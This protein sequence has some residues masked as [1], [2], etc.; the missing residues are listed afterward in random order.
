MKKEIF[1]DYILKWF[2]ELGF[3]RKSYLEE[4][5]ILDKSNVIKVITWMR[6]VWKSFILKQFIDEK[7]ESWVKKE[8]IFYLH[9]EDYRFW[10]KPDLKQ[11]WELFNYFLE[12]IYKWWDFYIFLDEIQNVDSWE[13]FV[14]TINEKYQNSAHIFITWSNSNLLSSELSTLLTWRFISLQVFPFSFKDYLEFK[15][16]EL[17]SSLD[18]KK[19]DYFEEYIKYWSLPEI[20]KIDDEN[21]KSN[22]LKTLVDSILFKDIITRYKLRKTTFISSLLKFIYTNTCSILSINSILKFLKQDIKSLDYETVDNYISYL[23]NS[24][25][26]N[27]IDSKNSK[28]KE[29]LK[30]NKKYYSYDLG[31]RNI[32]SN[33]F[34]I[35][36]ILE[37]YVYLELQRKWYKVWV[38]NNPNY[39]I[40]FFAEKNDE[41]IYFQVSYTIKNKETYNR[42]IKP[43]LLQKDNYKKVILT[44]DEE[45]REDRWIFIKNIINWSI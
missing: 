28:T 26:I 30:S 43:F 38:I 18:T 42:E 13:K 4:L 35:E 1:F 41:K 20:L 21:I 29:I 33:N 6:R 39:E 2:W 22:Y 11:L 32:Y 15:N 25:L 45:E 7:I 27:K 34:D 44:L 31:I 14:R 19:I 24:F 37:N 23:E 36:K 8:N 9:L 40:D 3:L 16:L 10:N 12:K 17:K 5:E